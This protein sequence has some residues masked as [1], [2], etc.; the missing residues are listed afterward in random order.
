MTGDDDPYEQ[1]L[2]KLFVDT[3]QLTGILDQNQMRELPIRVQLDYAWRL[4]PENTVPTPEQ[5]AVARQIAETHGASQSYMTSVA[6]GVPGDELN[7]L[8]ALAN[9]KGMQQAVA[10]AYY[11]GLLADTA[12]T[13][14]E[15]DAAAQLIITYYAYDAEPR[16]YQ[17]ALNLLA[18]MPQVDLPGTTT[19]V[20][21][22]LYKAVEIDCKMGLRQVIE[23]AY[24]TGVRQY[25]VFIT[26]TDPKR[27]QAAANCLFSAAEYLLN[28]V[29]DSAQATSFLDLLPENFIELLPSAEAVRHYYTA[30]LAVLRSRIAAGNRDYSLP[31]AETI[32]ESLRA[33]KA[34]K[35][36]IPF[37][38]TYIAALQ[39][40]A[41]IYA[42]R[43]QW[44][45]A[46]EILAELF[47]N[48][49]TLD[50]Q[51]RA[52]AQFYATML[53]ASILIK[54]KDFA[55]AEK[56][57]MD[58]NII[59]ETLT[60]FTTYIVQQRT[61]I[62]QM[63]I[64][65]Y[66]Q[67]PK[68]EILQQYADLRSLPVPLRTQVLLQQAASAAADKDPALMANVLGLLSRATVTAQDQRDY[69]ELTQVLPI[70]VLFVQADYQ[71]L[72]FKPAEQAKIFTTLSGLIARL[73]EPQR[74]AYQKRLSLAQAYVQVSA[75][76][77]ADPA[78]IARESIL[79]DISVLNGL[80]D[81]TTETQVY[82]LQL[83]AALGKA[84]F[85]GFNSIFAA[86]QSRLVTLLAQR[87]NQ[88]C[89][90]LAKEFQRQL[91]L[92]EYQY[93]TA[94]YSPEITQESYVLKQTALIAAAKAIEE[95][96][97]ATAADRQYASAVRELLQARQPR[98]IQFDWTKIK[99]KYDELKIAFTEETGFWDKK[100]IFDQMLDLAIELGYYEDIAVAIDILYFPEKETNGSGEL[101]VLSRQLRALLPEGFEFNRTEKGY[102]YYTLVNRALSMAEDI[103]A[104]LPVI[105]QLI[106]EL[107]E[108]Y[109][110][111][112]FAEFAPV[113]LDEPIELLRQ[114][115]IDNK[116][117]ALSA[118]Q[119]LATLSIKVMPQAANAGYL[120]Q[121]R[122]YTDPGSMQDFSAK[123]RIIDDL[124]QTVQPES[125]AAVPA[126]ELP[127]L[128]A[129]LL[130][131]KKDLLMRAVQENSSTY[132]KIISQLDV[133][134]AEIPPQT[135]IYR[136]VKEAVID[137]LQDL[138]RAQNIVDKEKDP[139]YK[140]PYSVARE[141]IAT[142]GSSEQTQYSQQL[143]DLLEGKPVIYNRPASFKERSAQA[144]VI[145]QLVQ[146][147]SLLYR[148]TLNPEYRVMAETFAPLLSKI[149]PKWDTAYVAQ[150]LDR[151]TRKHWLGLMPLVDSRLVQH[152][153]PNI[154]I[155]RQTGLHF[156]G[157][158][159]IPIRIAL[160]S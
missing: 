77:Y 85:I 22:P 59:A 132:N 23:T 46:K 71:G 78:A 119:G 96:I 152:R 157:I 136:K 3:A 8:L 138:F 21:D 70:E 26:E 98:E 133:L 40:N 109:G 19:K 43:G 82:I 75:R 72:L 17:K 55:G 52:D 25:A 90:S 11:E 104:A 15:K 30:R 62:I 29:K 84:D 2:E 134:L 106:S 103:P 18:R 124:L 130:D 154:S 69:P 92:L 13:V 137:Q 95:N 122:I 20:L 101:A 153:G 135:G 47:A 86:A 1:F 121:Y 48:I 145:S 105:E 32:I 110:K 112:S 87:D 108:M 139:I 27:A 102:A 142:L 88:G 160:Y 128:E 107:L 97:A 7:Q 5:V 149:Y 94:S 125:I 118:A 81:E 39:A 61:Q 150:G 99:Q 42:E 113:E 129:L 36:P 89:Q 146:L 114:A 68:P 127:Y 60:G 12:R 63:I 14:A 111:N 73:P 158:L 31:V 33:Q 67:W 100:R 120:A 65:L 16:Q 155:R 131:M 116:L 151:S 51:D 140:D 156:L 143:I 57:L 83:Q 35:K 76:A 79:A 53:Q 37:N 10:V 50:G 28:T 159:L 45:K 56:V 117:Q 24:L 4:L 80:Q 93:L 148:E 66:A 41:Q 126:V 9:F 44:T 91:A 123:K 147:Y 58:A 144:D 64:S 141:L 38:I 6:A 74:T 34:N 54:E 49:A 115:V